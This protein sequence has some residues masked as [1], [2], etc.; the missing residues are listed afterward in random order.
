VSDE[1]AV[2]LYVGTPSIFGPKN[3]AGG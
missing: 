2:L 1:E 3:Q